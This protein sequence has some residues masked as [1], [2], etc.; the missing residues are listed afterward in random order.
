MGRIPLILVVSL[1]VWGAVGPTSAQ[2][3]DPYSELDPVETS[4]MIL[5][6][7]LGPG[8]APSLLEFFDDRDVPRV[9]ELLESQLDHASPLMRTTAASRLVRRGAPALEIL[10]RLQTVDERSAL[11]VD[12]LASDVLDRDL[13]RTLLA[14]S[15]QVDVSDFARVVIL[16]VGQPD[17]LATQLDAIMA[18]EDLAPVGRGLAASGLTELGDARLE[19]WLAGLDDLSEAVRDRVIFDVIASLDALDLGAALREFDRLLQ[20]RPS[21]DALR[22]SV[23]IGLLSRSGPD[24]IASWSRLA[25]EARPGDLVAVGFLLISADQPCDQAFLDRFTSTDRMQLAIRSLLAASPSDRPRTALPLLELGHPATL[26]WLGGIDPDTLDPEII[27]RFVAIAAE[28]P[29]NPRLQA[30]V[31]MTASLM[32]RDPDR[33]SAL[34][35]QSG[36]DPVTMEL[37]LRG[38]IATQEAGVGTIARPIMNDS[39]RGLRAIALVAVATRGEPTEADWRR[40]VKLAAGGGGLPSD[41]RPLAAW[42]HLASENAIKRQ[43]PVITNP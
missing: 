1:V 39:N 24:G 34:L 11:I 9:R 7:S 43:L 42:Y 16:L 22:A 26:R 10:E 5:R 29:T 25:R 20:D 3:T 14:Q 33:F 31:E 30:A 40:L 15:N 17:D 19:A 18:D 12:M 37:L 2:G 41:L 32:E 38:L 23:T 21:N 13:A 8:G 27:E 4:T 36:E 35:A 6:R 28:R